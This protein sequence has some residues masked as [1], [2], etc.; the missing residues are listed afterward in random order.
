MASSIPTQYFS[1]VYLGGTASKINI[2]RTGLGLMMLTWTVNPVSDEQAFAAIKAAVDLVP[3]G[4]KLF[5]N[6]A[7]FYGGQDHFTANL[8]LLARFFATYPEFAEK[9]FLSVKGG[10]GVNA[11]QVVD[12]SAQNLR[13]SV[14]AINQALGGKKRMDLF[15]CARV[16]QKVPIEQVMQSLKGLVAEG[17]FDH[18]GVSEISAATLKRAASVAELAAVEIEVSPWSYEEETQKVLATAA[19][20]K[21]PIIAYSPLGRGFLTGEINHDTLAENDIRRRLSRFKQEAMEHNQ[22]IVD[23]LAAVAGNKGI[24]LAQLSLAW[25]S[26][27]GPHIVPIPGSSKVH[28]IQENFA[29]STIKL[30]ED[31]VNSIKEVIKNIGVQGGRYFDFSKE[32]EHRWG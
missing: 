25:V 13:R 4:E 10:T 7:E 8:E 1:G 23:A 20:L 17:K 30:T 24:T 2:H 21:I 19:D 31:E 5:L 32:M 18:I 6:S 12:G 28:R 26:N 14:D 3:E 16:D 11:V 9:V 27:L 22:K 29:A 15:E